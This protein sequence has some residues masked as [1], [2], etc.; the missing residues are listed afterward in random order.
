M[1]SVHID[2]DLDIVRTVNAASENGDFGQSGVKAVIVPQLWPQIA[3]E[4][5]A[6]VNSPA[7]FAY[8]ADGVLDLTAHCGFGLQ[9]SPV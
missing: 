3:E 2:V 8:Q 5:V 1:S 7:F 6:T 4:P 9:G